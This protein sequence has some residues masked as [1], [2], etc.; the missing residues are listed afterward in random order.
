[1][2]TTDPEG[3]PGPRPSDGSGVRL[4]LDPWGRL[5]L[6]APDG[7]RH[8]GVEPVRAFPISE[9]DRWYSFCDHQG[10]EV[11]HLRSVEALDPESRRLLEEEMAS[12][13]FVPVI[14]R[15]KRASA[16]GTPCDLDVETDRGPTRFTLDSE[17]DIR[18]LGPQRVLITDKRKLRYEI[19]D[20]LALDG[21]SRRIIER[22]F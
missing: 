15:I 17:D 18:H 9:P 19:P 3:P 21:H 12:R 14:R 22:F 4:S 11:F 1:M 5:V 8:A 6:E 20:I 10:H 13:E 2:T 7:Q 16:E